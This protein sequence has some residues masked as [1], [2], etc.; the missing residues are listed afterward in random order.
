MVS[1]KDNLIA[2]RRVIFAL[3]L[4]ELQGK[5]N[6][7]LGLGWAF[8]E[9]FIFIFG[10]SFARSFISGDEVHSI[11]ILNFMIIGMVYIQSF[12]TCLGSVS[13]SIKRNKPLYAFRQVQP[14]ASLITSALLE[15]T[16][17]AGA[18]ILLLLSV[19]LLKKDFQVDNPLLLIYLYFL[20]WTFC[21]SISLIF[22]IA[23]TYIPEINKIKGL[24]QRPIFFISCTFFSLQDIPREH[25][26]YLDW[27][28][29]VHF[30]ELTRY[31]CYPSYG[32]LGVSISYITEITVIFIFFALALYH[33]TWKKVL[34][35]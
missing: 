27:N 21:L 6:D 25:W 4:R 18:I 12:M 14:M 19:Y 22:G 3:F 1:F 5:F 11:P 13:G 17:K 2:W 32:N 33:L 35:R 16:I 8:F 20:L 10:L 7:K 31:A 34:S 15:F 9:P 26:H 24:I 28:P 30:I 29:L 23:A